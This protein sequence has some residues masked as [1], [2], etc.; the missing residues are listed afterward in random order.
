M[1]T[2]ELKDRVNK[3]GLTYDE[4]NRQLIAVRGELFEA[5]NLHAESIAP[6]KR[7][8][9]IHIVE[10]RGFYPKLKPYNVYV[11]VK[12]MSARN[13]GEVFIAGK[14]YDKELNEL[15][16]GYEV[17]LFIKEKEKMEGEIN[18]PPAKF[19]EVMK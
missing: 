4:L 18:Y 8:D 14:R 13:S 5:R 1:D 9:I 3:L 12:T 17:T 11:K 16:Q 15:S 7:G 2:Q 19:I 6:F 10:M